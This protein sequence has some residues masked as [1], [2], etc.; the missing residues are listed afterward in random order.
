[1]INQL[2]STFSRKIDY[3]YPETGAFWYSNATSNLLEN[4]DYNNRLENLSGVLNYNTSL[5]KHNFRAIGGYQQETFRYDTFFASKTNFVSDDVT[6]FNL[7][8]A[9]PIASGDAYQYALRSYFGRVNYNFDERYLVELNLRYD[10]SSRYA[11][12]NRYGAFKSGSLGWRFTQ[13]K[14]HGL[15]S[16]VAL[17]K[18][19]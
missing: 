16:G 4:R 6:V 1:M 13:E 18:R 14:F 9:N 2:R 12:G 3:F 10:G 19:R 7:G 11:P 8:A 15:E 17:V 5:G